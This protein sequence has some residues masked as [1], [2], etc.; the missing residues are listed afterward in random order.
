MLFP[1]EQSES[2]WEG[3]VR[4]GRSQGWSWTLPVTSKRESQEAKNP[5][6]QIHVSGG[7]GG[8]DGGVGGWVWGWGGVMV[9]CVGVWGGALEAVG[10]NKGSPLPSK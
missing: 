5:L 4:S 9:V 6:L 10:G 1:A 3:E 8:G 7:G 2:Y